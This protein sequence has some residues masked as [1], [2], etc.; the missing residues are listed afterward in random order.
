[1]TALAELEFALPLNAIRGKST[2]HL[3]RAQVAALAAPYEGVTVDLDAGDGRPAYRLALGRPGDFIIAVGRSRHSMADVSAKAARHQVH[4]GAPNLLYVAAR[5][6]RP[7]ADLARIASQVLVAMPSGHL[8][9]AILNGDPSVIGGIVS[10]GALSA[11][12]TIVIG[13]SASHDPFKRITPLYTRDTIEP[14]VT[15]AGARIS[16][17]A[18]MTDTDVAKFEA[19]WLRPLTIEPDGRLFLIEGKVRRIPD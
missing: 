9:E 18:W 7:P 19:K 6:I 3:Q 8:L 12:I 5:D 15:A 10:T 11:T 2:S 4:G 13:D 16:K 17:A 1:M 14:P